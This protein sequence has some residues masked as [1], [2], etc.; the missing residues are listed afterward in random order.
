MTCSTLD[1]TQAVMTL[2]TRSARTF[3]LLAA[4][5]LA[6]S[7]S[8]QSIDHAKALFADGQ[9]AAAKSELLSLEKAKNGSAAVA[10]HLG[11]IATIENDGDEAIRQ[12]ERAV[13]LDERNALYHYWLGAA[14]ADAALH[15]NKIKQPFMG[16]RVLKEME[17]SVELDPD[18]LDARASLAGFYAMAPAFMGGGMEKARAQAAELT[19]RSPMRGALARAEIADQ[20]KNRG[21]EETAYR[22]AIAAAPD[23]SAAYFALGYAYA[24]D[25]RGAEAF[26]IL[27]EYMK[28]RPD[29]RWSLYQA[30]RFAAI[31][32]R[33]LDRGESALEEFLAAPPADAYA[34]NFASAHVR[35]GQIAEK[36]GAK[37]QAREQY[38]TALK[39]NPKNEAAKRALDALK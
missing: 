10:Y 8:A 33:E 21:A 26:A 1:V 39:I 5:W 14:V 38:K 28:R 31:S 2:R 16:R 15:V 12:F 11:R 4:I 23:S 36:R 19:R 25:A 9:Y 13:H 22:E 32:G 6:P 29:D 34:V 7:M 37:E 3:I 20:E 35:L 17:R 24:R 18:Q 27:A 30:G